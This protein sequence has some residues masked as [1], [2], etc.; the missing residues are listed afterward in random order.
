M[1]SAGRPGCHK[2]RLP[3]AEIQRYQRSPSGRS[4]QRR[5]GNRLPGRPEGNTSFHEDKVRYFLV[6]VVRITVGIERFLLAN[7]YRPPG[8]DVVAFL[9][10]LF[11]LDE[12]LAAMGGHLFFIG[13]FNV[14]GNTPNGVDKQMLH[15]Y[16]AST[17][18]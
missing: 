9:N 12:A 1:G 6:L 2:S 13:D 14:P 16:R 8:F 18:W 4:S 17:T 15:G 5:P 11:E 7:I 3:P 10:E